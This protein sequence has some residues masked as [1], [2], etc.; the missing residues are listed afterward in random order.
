MVSNMTLIRTPNIIIAENTVPQPVLPKGTQSTLVAPTDLEGGV[1]FAKFAFRFDQITIRTTGSTSSPTGKFLI[2][3]PI[4][5]T[6]AALVGSVTAFSLPGVDT[7]T[8]ALNEGVIEIK[9]GVFVIMW[10][11]DSGAGTFTLRTYNASSVSLMNTAVPSDMVP[12][13]MTTSIAANGVSPAT[14]DLTEGGSDV[15]GSSGTNVMPIIR[16]STS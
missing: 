5:S 10:G 13:S 7:Y 11:R 3:Q 1:F 9:P 14:L 2:Y 12:V 15:T 6:T 8:M 4:D 16:L